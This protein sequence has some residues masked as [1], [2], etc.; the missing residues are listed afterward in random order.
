MKYKFKI[1]KK[2]KFKL[3]LILLVL[4][5]LLLLLTNNNRKI[6]NYFLNINKSMISNTS[7]SFQLT[8]YYKDNNLK[9]KYFKI[10]N[11]QYSFSLK[12]KKIKL[13][14]N[15]NCFDEYNNLIP[16]KSILLNNLQIICLIKIN[17]NIVIETLSN[18]YEN[19]YLYCID[20]F[21]MKERLKIGIKIYINNNYNHNNYYIYYFNI[22]IF[23]YNNL[24]YLNDTLFEPLYI[25]KRYN[26]LIHNIKNKNIKDF[27][28]KKMYIKYPIFDLKRDIYS[29]N[30]LWNFK[31]I[32]NHYFCISIHNNNVNN[33]NISQECKYYFYINI[34]DNNKNIYNKTH[35]LFVDFIFANMPTDDTYPVFE[36]M[37]K[38]NLS[39]HYVT[40][41]ANIYNYFCNQTKECLTI[42][43]VNRK[44]YN[45]YGDFL[46]KY[47]FLFLK[48]KSVISGK[49]NIHHPITSLFNKI[50][51]I[52]YIA[53][54]HGVCYFK[55]FLYTQN[56]IYGIKT[57]NKLLLVNSAP[58]ISIAKKYG[59]KD[60]NI[61]KLNLPRWDKYNNNISA[62]YNNNN[63]K[64]KSNSI[65]IM[66]TW[67]YMRANKTISLYYNKNIIKL[68]IDHNLNKE[69]VKSNIILYF[70]LHRFIYNKY[71]NVFQDIIKS[72]K[73]VKFIN[74]G[75]ISE[76]LSK[77]NLIVSDFS[78]VVFDFMYRRKPIII[79]IPDGN[80]PDIKNIY[81]NQYYTLIKLVK[82]GNIFFENKFLKVKDVINKII[83]YIKNNFKLEKKLKN[84]YDTFGFK[85]G[86]NINKFIKYLK[87]LK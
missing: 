15:I 59:W 3:K 11:I 36:E 16:P 9:I 55:Y 70:T 81:N 4:L 56:Q 67:R 46:Q 6:I 83:Y 65:F 14:Y 52:T 1:I 10:S 57:N 12:Y 61:I 23:K 42:I 48:L 79:Y 21:N 45:N 31:N 25:L 19:K 58:I 77:A 78:S 41:K 24:N 71:K 74:Q 73:N 30:I 27:K 76:C 29:K 64:L 47:L 20:F 2:S 85:V 69:L 54:G 75:Q 32:Y 53:V 50:E 80:D 7:N 34:L 13:E 84:F 86:N 44:L 40:E 62:L 51:Y 38:Q 8:N 49:V 26:I 22:K 43:P 63:N 33:Y 87:K 18:I 66:F 5:Y 39:A 28:V 35:Y 72:K 82:D 60:K 37:I 68:L 17:K